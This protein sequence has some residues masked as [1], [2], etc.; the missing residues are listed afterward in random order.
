MDRGRWHLF[1]LLT[2]LANNSQNFL[3]ASHSSFSCDCCQSSVV[4]VMSG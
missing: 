4:V 2:G 1:P 3:I